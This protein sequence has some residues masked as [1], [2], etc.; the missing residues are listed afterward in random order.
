LWA[1]I[2]GDSV[3][4]RVRDEGPGFPT[5]FLPYAFERFSRPETSRTSGG[6]G[7]GLESS[8]DGRVAAVNL[9]H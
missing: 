7:L 6:A 1:E 3:V 2:L 5:D 9:A 4:L 8:P